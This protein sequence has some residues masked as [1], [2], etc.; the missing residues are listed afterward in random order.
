MIEERYFY[1]YF[2]YFSRVCVR[3][4]TPVSGSLTRILW[5]LCGLYRGNPPIVSEYLFMPPPLDHYKHG[6]Q[7]TPCINTTL[8]TMGTMG[9][10]KTPEWANIM[11]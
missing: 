2:Q 1:L 10:I 3:Q 6:R 8:L 11:E 5:F 4:I 9:V 7:Y